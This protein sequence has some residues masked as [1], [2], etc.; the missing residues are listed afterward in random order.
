MGEADMVMSKWFPNSYCIVQE[1][2]FFQ[3]DTKRGIQ[4]RSGTSSSIV[5]NQLLTR[6]W[7]LSSD[8]DEARAR[9]RE[10]R[11]AENVAVF[12]CSKP[13]VRG[14]AKDISERLIRPDI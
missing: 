14:L 6:S 5:G 2:R 4:K 13:R 7:R 1:R 10:P 12:E 11:Q 3:T 9:P 8:L